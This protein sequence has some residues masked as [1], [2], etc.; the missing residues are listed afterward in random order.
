MS[1]ATFSGLADRRTHWQD[2]RDD[3]ELLC[4]RLRANAMD[5][6]ASNLRSGTRTFPSLVF[7][8]DLRE[9]ERL[10]R[11]ACLAYRPRQE[12]QRPPTDRRSILAKLL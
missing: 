1:V 2:A 11:L 10:L 4:H 6:Q 7:S 5:R 12:S 8:L 9:C 3:V